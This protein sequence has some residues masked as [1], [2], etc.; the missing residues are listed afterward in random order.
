M[1]FCPARDMSLVAIKPEGVR[2][3]LFDE[4]AISRAIDCSRR[5]LAFSLFSS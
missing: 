2:L 4:D 3:V 5:A 1:R